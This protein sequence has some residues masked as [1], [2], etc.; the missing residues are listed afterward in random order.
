MDEGLVGDVEDGIEH[1]V[2]CVG[3]ALLLS[4]LFLLAHELVAVFESIDL[5]S[6]LLLHGV[7]HLLLLEHCILGVELLALIVLGFAQFSVLD[8]DLAALVSPPALV[9]QLFLLLRLPLHAVEDLCLAAVLLDIGQQV[10]LVGDHT[11]APALTIFAGFV[12]KRLLCLAPEANRGQSDS[13][14]FGHGATQAHGGSREKGLSHLV[15]AVQLR[16]RDSSRQRLGEGFLGVVVR[17]PR[18]DPVGV[19]GFF[20]LV[21]AILDL[22]GS[23]VDLGDGGVVELLSLLVLELELALLPLLLVGH[24]LL[25]VLDTLGEPLFQE[26]RVS[27][28]LVDLSPPNFL[29]DSVLLLFLDVGEAFGLFRLTDGLIV[30]LLEVS[31]NVHGLLGLVE[32]LKACFEEAGLHLVVRLLI[33]PDLERGLVIAYLTR[34]AEDGDVS[35]RVDLLKDHPQLVKQ[36]EGPASLFLHNLVHLLGV[37]L[38]IQVSEGG[39]QLF[40]ILNF[41]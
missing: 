6:H 16:G 14:S 29:L 26:A 39:L 9:S 34:L 17:D 27:L 37:E 20:E 8:D 11:H 12:I 40:K 35:G 2:G 22:A 23:I 36:A 41:G 31:L 38:D 18:V 19:Q 3:L 10:Q 7:Q 13:T 30:E 21:D 4:F 1:L 33:R 25:P 24:V 28:Q 5:A 15:G 32:S